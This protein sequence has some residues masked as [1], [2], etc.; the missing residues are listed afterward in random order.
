MISMK[1]VFVWNQEKRLQV[2]RDVCA[3][4]SIWIPYKN[5]SFDD[6]PIDEL[7]HLIVDDRHGVI[8]CF[9]PKVYTQLPHM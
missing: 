6:I 8:Y 9:V 5:R 7:R 2:F 4:E 1:K 3:N